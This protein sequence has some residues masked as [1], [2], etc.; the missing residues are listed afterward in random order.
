MNLLIPIL[1]SRHLC[2]GSSADAQSRVRR[3]QHNV[4][5][6]GFGNKFAAFLFLNSCPD[7]QI[8]S[9]Y[10]MIGGATARVGG[11][12][13]VQREGQCFIMAHDSWVLP[14]TDWH[15]VGGIMAHSKRQQE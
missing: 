5:V 9:Q 6:S 14:T 4:A 2:I 12:A 13:A 8:L 15:F 11:G 1:S 3:T 10:A 7:A